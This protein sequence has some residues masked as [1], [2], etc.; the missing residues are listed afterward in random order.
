[1]PA[2]TFAESPSRVS[3]SPGDSIPDA[4]QQLLHRLKEQRNVNLRASEDLSAEIK[5]RWRIASSE[6]HTSS[7]MLYEILE[8][9]WNEWRRITAQV[10]R[11]PVL[12]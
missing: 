12:K 1:M 5:R 11:T 3:V 10:E 7:S 9:G 8:Y 6:G 4:L 2:A